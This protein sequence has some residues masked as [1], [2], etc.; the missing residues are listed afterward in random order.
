MSK[1]V[2]A[3]FDSEGERIFRTSTGKH[4]NWSFDL[5]HAYLFSSEK[6]VRNAWWFDSNEFDLM[7]VKIEICEEIK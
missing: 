5:D 6:Q 1:F 4:N 2:I 7:P 3:S